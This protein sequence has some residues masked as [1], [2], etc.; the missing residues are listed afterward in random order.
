MVSSDSKSWAQDRLVTSVT[1]EGQIINAKAPEALWRMRAGH[2]S[3]WEG[4]ETAWWEEGESCEC[5][6]EQ[7]SESI[8]VWWQVTAKADSLNLSAFPGVPRCL[9]ITGPWVARQVKRAV[10]GSVVSTQLKIITVRMIAES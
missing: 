5:L 6:K 7:P 2:A 9:E 8:A 1:S 10:D 4:G 3:F